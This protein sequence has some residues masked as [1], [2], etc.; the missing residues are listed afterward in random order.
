MQHG[1]VTKYATKELNPLGYD[2]TKSQLTSSLCYLLHND[3][4]CGLVFDLE[5]GGNKFI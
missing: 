2:T 1:I 3:F 5:D 4:S